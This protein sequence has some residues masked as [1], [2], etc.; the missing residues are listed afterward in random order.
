MQQS[1]RRAS[2]ARASAPRPARLSPPADGPLQA[3]RPVPNLLKRQ[4]TITRRD[5][6][7]VT[8]ITYIRVAKLVVSRSGDGAR[9]AE[10][11]RVDDGAGD[12]S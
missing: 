2:D 7:C 8:D 1:P 11:R 6:A 4:L 3:I 9:L 5:T 12:P 10:D